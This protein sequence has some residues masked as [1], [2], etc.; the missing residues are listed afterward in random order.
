MIRHCIA[1][2]LTAAAAATPASATDFTFEVPVSVRDVP[3]LTQVRVSCLVS[4]LPAGTDGSASETNVIGRGDVTVDAPGG[5]YEG[6]VTVPVENGGTRRSVDARSYACGLEGLG[7]NASGGLIT[8]G[9][10]WSL[11]LS[12]MVGADLISQ[13]LSTE[14]N[15]P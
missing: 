5:S 6:T 14:A 7:R 2:L 15:L 3:L 10:N 4:V 9:T 13:N 12:R 1:A 8:L 11:A